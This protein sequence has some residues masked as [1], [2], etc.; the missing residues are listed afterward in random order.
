MKKMFLLFSHTLT[1][2]QKEDAM[3]NLKVSEFVSLPDELQQI[4]SNISPYEKTIE[5]FL[6]PIK[7]FLNKEAKKEDVVLIQ[8]DFGATFLMVLFA[9]QK[10]LT[11]VYATTQ[12]K[13]VETKQESKIIKKSVFSHVQFR[14]Y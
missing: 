6:E 8:G 7:D 2:E 11:P 10:S 9:K 1:D 3:K 12:R 13:V 4:W 14:S 5:H